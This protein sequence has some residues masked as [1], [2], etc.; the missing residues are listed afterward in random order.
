MKIPDF[1]RK[2]GI[3]WNFLGTLDPNV[4][5]KNFDTIASFAHFFAT[6]LFGLNPGDERINFRLE[7]FLFRADGQMR[8]VR[9]TKNVI[10]L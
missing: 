6:F 5:I 10:Q 1:Q 8:R 3:S 4:P 7:V 9:A 2:S